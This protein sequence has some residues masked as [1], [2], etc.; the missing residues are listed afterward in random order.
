VRHAERRVVFRHLVRIRLSDGRVLESPSVLAR[1]EQLMR[2]RIAERQLVRRVQEDDAFTPDGARGQVTLLTEVDARVNGQPTKAYAFA[3][4]HSRHFAIL[5]AKS[6]ADAQRAMDVLFSDIRYWDAVGVLTKA[7]LWWAAWHTLRVHCAET[8]ADLRRGQPPLDKDSTYDRIAERTA[9]YAEHG[10]SEEQYGSWESTEGMETYDPDW[11]TV[12]DW[13]DAKPTALVTQFVTK[14]WDSREIIGHEEEDLDA[15]TIVAF[16]S[17]GLAED[18]AKEPPTVAQMLSSVHATKL[19]QW[20]Q[21]TGSGFKSRNT[22]ALRDHLLQ[23]QPAF[24]EGRLR[25]KERPAG[26]RLLTPPGMSWRQFQHFRQ[27]YRNMVETM[28]AWLHSG[29]VAPEADRY[30]RGS[31]VSMS[32]SS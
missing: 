22:Q 14:A 13:F 1:H 16:K 31:A 15:A 6:R 27:A 20:I 3:R 21:E 11:T 25:A 23:Q 17:N 28:Q 24:L 7:H 19:R 12:F 5:F 30:F 26:V 9:W 18:E 8:A 32:N 29:N 10:L 4:P 2:E